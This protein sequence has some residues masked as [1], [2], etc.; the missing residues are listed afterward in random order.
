MKMK[1]IY[2]DIDVLQISMEKHDD[3][4]PARSDLISI[5]TMSNTDH[6]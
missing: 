4:F 6:F 2:H 1:K 5:K 3:F